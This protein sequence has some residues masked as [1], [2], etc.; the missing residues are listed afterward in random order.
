MGDA[1][2]WLL[3]AGL[4]WLSELTDGG[5]SESGKCCKG[6][7]HGCG[8]PG[9]RADR[10]YGT[11]YCDEACQSTG[12]CCYDYTR[13]CPAR[14]CVVSEWSHWSGCA[15]QCQPNVRVRRR[16]I[17][18]EPQNHGD[19]CPALEERAGCLEYMNYQGIHCG[20]SHVPAF[21]STAEY[22]KERRK[23]A[24]VEESEISEFRCAIALK[25]LKNSTRSQ[26]GIHPKSFI[27]YIYEVQSG[28]N[29]SPKGQRC[30]C[31]G[32][33]GRDSLRQDSN[34]IKGTHHPIKGKKGP[35]K[36]IPLGLGMRMKGIS[37]AR[38]MDMAEEQT[39][40]KR[41]TPV[42]LGQMA[43]FQSNGSWENNEKGHI[44]L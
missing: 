29:N 28:S 13:T 39:D 8:G 32:G 41:S 20:L 37:P 18:Q 9:W 7:D 10:V 5:C 23:R 24:L 16:Y 38:A 15:E 12:D 31:F 30:G 3:L 27:S 11:C 35:K 1:G 36:A 26:C 40:W 4:L 14:P 19:P 44:F 25:D 34:L 22:N 2:Q 43:G 21:I 17:E 6:R 42:G 33:Q